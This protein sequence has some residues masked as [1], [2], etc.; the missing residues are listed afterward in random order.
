MHTFH[1]RRKRQPA[2]R[3]LPTVCPC[4]ITLST[5]HT[6]PAQAA[7]SPSIFH[8]HFPLQ[9]PEPDA[10]LFVSCN[11]RELQAGCDGEGEGETCWDSTNTGAP[12]IA[13]EGITSRGERDV[14]ASA[15]VACRLAPTGAVVACHFT[16]KRR[17]LDADVQTCNFRASFSRK[18]P[19]PRR[20][21]EKRF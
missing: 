6:P 9:F 5:A 14:A 15:P 10:A 20:V 7:T 19:P 1:R 12:Q 16:R 17:D 13:R 21:R 4:F 11:L 8:F 3:I 18:Y 2:A